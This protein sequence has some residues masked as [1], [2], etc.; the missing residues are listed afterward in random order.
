MKSIK[1]T[2]FCIIET[3]DTGEI[4]FLMRKNKPIGWSLPGGK[5]DEY[6][7]PEAAMAREVFEETGLM[8]LDNTSRYLGAVKLKDDKIGHVYKVWAKKFNVKLADEEHSDFFW[9]RDWSKLKLAGKVKKM[10]KLDK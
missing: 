2:A 1:Q 9:A 6:E 8:I 7:K 10:L 5:F 3:P 4:L